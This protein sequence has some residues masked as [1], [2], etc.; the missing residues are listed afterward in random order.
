MKGTGDIAEMTLRKSTN[1]DLPYIMA[2]ISDAQESLRLQ[3]IDQ[4]QNQYPNEDTILNDIDKGYSY[5]FIDEAEQK[6][7]A[8]VAI[9]FDG[10][11]TYNNIYYGK[12]ILE[13]P[14]GVIHR[15]AVHKE[16][17]SSGIGAKLIHQVQELVKKQGVPSLRIDTHK[18][19]VPMQKLLKKLAFIQCGII[20]VK[21]G[22]ERIAFEK[23]IREDFNV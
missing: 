15:I 13:E 2:I 8:T 21:D 22:S 1:L 23:C 6:I 4:W 17:L 14:Y 18:D 10:E 3:N 9:S 19:N 16:Y 11:E 7:V 20:Y 12:W 5:V